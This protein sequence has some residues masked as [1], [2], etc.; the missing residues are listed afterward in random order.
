MKNVLRSS[1]IGANSDTLERLII[2]EVMKVTLLAC[3][4]L[5][6]VTSELYFH[7]QYIYLPLFFKIR[8]RANATPVQVAIIYT[9]L[10]LRHCTY[11]IVW[12][13]ESNYAC[14]NFQCIHSFSSTLKDYFRIFFFSPGGKKVAS[15]IHRGAEKIISKCI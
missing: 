2:E 13:C 3:P 6:S 7:N 12:E 15:S 8:I 4:C 11:C 1:F 9:S 14:F 5:I 10:C